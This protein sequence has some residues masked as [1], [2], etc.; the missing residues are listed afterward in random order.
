M[1]AIGSPEAGLWRH[2]SND[3]VKADDA[4]AGFFDGLRGL[5]RSACRLL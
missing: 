1:P 5:G 2:D 4:N 3:R